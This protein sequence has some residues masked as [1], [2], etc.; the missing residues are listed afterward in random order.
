LKARLVESVVSGWRPQERH[1]SLSRDTEQVG[2]A[3]AGETLIAES[4]CFGSPELVSE[5]VQDQEIGGEDLY[6]QCPWAAL[7]DFGVRPAL[8]ALLLDLC[9]TLE[10]NLDPSRIADEPCNEQLESVQYLVCRVTLKCRVTRVGG[11]V[12][13]ASTGHRERLNSVSCRPSRLPY[14][15]CP[16]SAGS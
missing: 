12:T 2:D 3:S 4:A 8:T 15:E 7:D 1:Y 16:E 10:R 6:E 14:L 11:G 13:A 9:R 5:C